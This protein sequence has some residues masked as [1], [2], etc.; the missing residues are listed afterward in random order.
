MWARGKGIYGLTRVWCKIKY[1]WVNQDM[2]R[3]KQEGNRGVDQERP[4]SKETFCCI[5]MKRTVSDTVIYCEV[6]AYHKINLYL[7]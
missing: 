3:V 2:G 7:G 5:I 4:V 6:Y 1:L